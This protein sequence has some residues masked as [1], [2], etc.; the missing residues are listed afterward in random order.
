MEDEEKEEV[1]RQEI[2]EKFLL[3]LNKDIDPELI[4][5]HTI[6]SPKNEIQQRTP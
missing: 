4:N 5:Y 1:L 2:H 3:E 6:L